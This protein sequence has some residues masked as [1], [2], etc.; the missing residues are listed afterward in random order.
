MRETQSPLLFA[1]LVYSPENPR[2]KFT[3]RL[4]NNLK[5]KVYLKA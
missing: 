5:D 1:T 2:N 4:S 3:A